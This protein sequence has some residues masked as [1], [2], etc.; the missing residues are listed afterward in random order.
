MN[1]Y[2]GFFV[3]LILD[4]TAKYY[5]TNTHRMKYEHWSV[6]VDLPNRHRRWRGNIREGRGSRKK[7]Q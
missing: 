4:K 2:D 6:D 5:H 3:C 1:V 7:R